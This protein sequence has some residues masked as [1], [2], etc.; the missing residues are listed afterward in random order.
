MAR[1]SSIISYRLGST[2]TPNVLRAGSTFKASVI[3]CNYHRTNLRFNSSIGLSTASLFSK[4]V[5]VIIY[6]L[7]VRIHATAQ[8]TQ[9]SNSKIAGYIGYKN[10]IGS[11]RG[12]QKNGP[13]YLL[14]VSKY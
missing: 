5:I 10:I 8:K 3:E 6:T 7:F 2:H 14:I 11:R 12:R 13:K 1:P 4:I 9:S